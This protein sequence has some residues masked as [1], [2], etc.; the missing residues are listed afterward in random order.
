MAGMQ[1]GEAMLFGATLQLW[2]LP[3]QIIM[4]MDNAL[5]C[6]QTFKDKDGSWRLV[7]ASMKCPDDAQGPH[8]YLH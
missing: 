8:K 3:E 1:A 5:T 6:R 2:L 4:V 7:S